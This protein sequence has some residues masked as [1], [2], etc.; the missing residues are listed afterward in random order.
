[1]NKPIL[2]TP[3]TEI[4]TALVG[5]LGT[6]GFSDRPEPR[7][8][9]SQD[10]WTKGV[11]ADF[12][13]S[14][15][16]LDELAAAVSAAHKHGVSL[17]PR[18]GGMSYTKGYTPDRDGVG[19]LDLTRMNRIVE[20]SADDMYVT[21]EAGCTWDTLH[22]ALKEKGLRT[23]FWGPLSGISSTIGGGVSQNNAFFGGSL[24][25]TTAES[26]LA[27]TVVLADGAVIRTGTAGGKGGKPFFR[28]YGPDLTGLFCGDGGAL[29]YK[30]EITMR[31]IPAPAHEDWASFEFSSRDACAQAMRDLAKQNIACEIFG[32]DPNLQRV[33]LQRASLTADAKALG[34][35][36]K[37]QGSLLKGLKEGAKV[38]L[39]GRSFVDDAAYSLHVVVEGQSKD[40]VRDGMAKL[41]EICASHQGQRSEN[42]IP[43]II[44]A[45]PFGPLNNIL[46]PDGERWVP[47]H[48]IVPMSEGPQT[49]AEL[50]AAFEA[51][52]GE[53]DAHNIIT[54]F[55]ITTVG[56]NGY[57]IEPVFLWPEELFEIHEQTV[58]ADHLAKLARHAPNPEAT[59]VVEKARQTVLDVFSKH[60]AA[61]FQVG[62]TY[63]YKERRNPTDWALLE[64][65]KE[66]LDPDARVNPGILGLGA[67]TPEAVQTTLSARNPRTGVTDFELEAT[68]KNEMQ[69]LAGRARKAQQDWAASSLDERASA[70][71]KL[72]AA[73]KQHA[74]EISAAL[75][76]DTGRRRIA[77][78]EVDGV[79]ASIEGWI[80]QAPH[81]LPQGWTDGLR[82]PAL[83]HAPQFSPYALVGVI[84]PWNFPL[85]LSM[86]DTIP[87]L[88]AGCSVIIKPSEVTSRFVSP[89]QTA[90]AEAGLSDILSFAPGDG[91]TG[92]ALIDTAD[93][94]CF[95]G[96]VATGRKV[97]MGCAARMI[98]AFLELG[99]KDPLLVL[100]GA[101][102]E[103]ATDAA[104]RGSVMSTGQACQSIER[105][106]V[107][108]SLYDPF[109]VRLAEKAGNVR[110]NWPEVDAGE[111]G[112]II[113]DKQA[114]IL[115]RH[116]G[117]AL[118]KGARLLAG[119]EIENLGGGL[120]LRP[121]LL[122][123]AT[124][125]MIVMREETFGPI[126]PVMAF[127]NNAQA[128][129]LAND[130]EYGLSA[131]VFGATL[132]D[133]E[134]VGRHI[135]AGAISLND[136]ALTAMFHE[137][138][139]H[140]FKLSG[141][142]GSRMGPAGFQRFF[143]RKALIANTGSP[144]PISAF[145]EDTDQ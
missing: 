2:S 52:R 58:E 8:L 6:D 121:T 113:F 78:L 137:A 76:A 141:L 80:S 111:I 114:D 130:T 70:L 51:M 120:W 83:R 44:R 95:T 126:M 110:L 27:M 106:Y 98:P 61:H 3:D 28:H 99:G 49:W 128:I 10:I 60:G 87:A 125:D 42:S 35:V 68:S 31:L 54:G 7:A 30:A 55:L 97:A 23:P 22:R 89:L 59:A 115:K 108:Q 136:A 34:N 96:S 11:R 143:R 17:N 75:E 67:I 90:I 66:A 20:I 72:A 91:A 77:K 127:E 124:H 50:D 138:E 103:L 81:L 142:G 85:T 133:A 53:L 132:E 5:A 92:A 40:G 37:S 65:I 45:N 18:G 84:S 57:L 46:G 135:D 140:A 4:K 73:V 12:V 82:N 94:I 107:H 112:P 33:R 24:Y 145:A 64:R 104:L 62:R 26:V 116:I 13:A 25:G 63:P 47:I 139:K 131:A 119:G 38:A 74:A 39:A 15:A 32:F 14:P 144:A 129:A 56:A 123:D 36:I 21:V 41:K 9:M 100:E 122:A 101:D 71:H 102:L 86:I 93:A 16:N 88:L 43:K 69:A 48:G 109:V 105:I 29:G 79:A 19:I 118:E 117:D 134:A 1:M